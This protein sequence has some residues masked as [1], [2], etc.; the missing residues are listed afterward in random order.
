[1]TTALKATPH[2]AIAPPE[3]APIADM[4]QTGDASTGGGPALRP[5]L[6]VAEAAEL[7]GVSEWLVLQQ[8]RV[9]TL[10]HKRCGRRIVLSRERLMAWLNDT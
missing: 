9:G 2:G 10:P 1:M 3:P 5:V 7:L 4:A 8:I 6:S